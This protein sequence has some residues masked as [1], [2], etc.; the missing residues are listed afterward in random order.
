MAVTIEV[1]RGAGDRPGAEIREPLL[2]ESLEAAL[3]RGRA[4]LDA[5]AHGWERVSLEADYRLDLALGDLVEVDDPLQGMAW[6][7]QIVGIAHRFAG[8]APTTTLDVRR[9]IT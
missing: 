9:P 8:G 4:E 5:N 7:G 2:G 6:R 3:A 1:Y